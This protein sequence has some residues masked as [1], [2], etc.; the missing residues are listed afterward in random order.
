M[1]ANESRRSRT[2]P[3]DEPK[4]DWWPENPYPES[5]FPMKEE[6]Y[7]EVV[8]DPHTRT[9]LSGCLGRGFWEAASETIWGRFQ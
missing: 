2:M 6:R 9:A 3:K 5:V 7:A 4:P 8:P 1:P